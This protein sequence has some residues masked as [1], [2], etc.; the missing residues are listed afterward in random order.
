MEAFTSVSHAVRIH[1]GLRALDA[2]PAEVRRVSASRI[3]VVCGRSVAQHSGIIERLQDLLGD[4]LAGAFTRLS[5][6]APLPDVLEAVEAARQCRADLLLAIGA[7][8]VLKA[9][10]VI[11]ILLAESAPIEQLVTQ[12]PVNEPP[13]SPRLRQPKLPIINIL[14]A[15]TSAQSRA[16]AALKNT[17]AGYRMEFYDPKTRPLAIFWDAD[18]LLSAP[19]SLALSTGMGVYWRALM[20]IG[21]VEQANPLVQGSRY[22]AFRLASRAIGRMADPHDCQARIDMCAAALL[23]N[24]DEEDGGRPFD[25]HWIARVVYALGAATF[26]L[27]EGVDQGS[28]HAALTGPALRHFGALAPQ[29]VQAIGQTLQVPHGANQTDYHRL[30]GDAADHH[31]QSLGMP[32]SLSELGVARAQLPEILRLSLRNF[33]ADRERGLMRNQEL[34]Q[35]T[36]EDAWLS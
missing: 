16:G 15:A 9:A 20:N 17:D 24:R 33:N 36:L 7:G 2:L 4:T 29:A 3:F 5:K 22:Q 6:D 31:F 25:A 8:S 13:F 28:A 32:A 18:A 23:Q 26:N 35:A 10:R 30:V 19:P 14:T 21:A 34:V 1:A 11:A 27:V 12:Y